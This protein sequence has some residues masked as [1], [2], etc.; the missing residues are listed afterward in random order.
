[1][2]FNLSCE[3]HTIVSS[4]GR[5]ALIAC[6]VAADAKG[7]HERTHGAAAASQRPSERTNTVRHR[8]GPSSGGLLSCT[9][10][11][12]CTAALGLMPRGAL[13]FEQLNLLQDRDLVTGLEAMACTIACSCAQRQH[14]LDA[15][16]NCMRWCR[17]KSLRTLCKLAR[18]GG[19]RHRL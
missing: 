18:V 15:H 10:C 6:R 11:G 14:Q 16:R 3:P 1:M 7:S 12:G 5:A 19:K 9:S 4:P 2:G 13:W 17:V 8:R